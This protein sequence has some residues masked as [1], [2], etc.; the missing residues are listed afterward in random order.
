MF[1]DRPDRIVTS[2]ST[3]NYIGNWS[4]G[5]D[6]FATNAPNAVLVVDEKEGQKTA[7]IEL[8]N[9]VYDENKK[10]LKY[11]ISVENTPIDLVDEFGRSTLVIDI[12]MSNAGTFA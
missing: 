3:D 8:F 6:S 9:P 4:S 2:I 10:T 7:I 1:S 12:G 11:E 5:L